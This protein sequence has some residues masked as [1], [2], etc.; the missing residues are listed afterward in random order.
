M[1]GC[2]GGGGQPQLLGATPNAGTSEFPPLETEYR[3][4]PGDELRIVVVGNDEMSVTVPVRPDGRI[5]APG[6]G[7]IEVGGRTIAIVTEELR[8]QLRRLIRYPEV[9]VM[10]VKHAEQV[11]Y[12]LGEVEAPGAKPYVPSMT[13]LHALGSAGGARRS[14]KTSSVVVLRRTGPNEMEVY[15]VDLAAALDGKPTARDFYL[16]PYDLIY[17]PRTFIA[18]LN[19]FMDQYVRQNVIPFTAYIEGWRAFH[20]KEI[21]WRAPEAQ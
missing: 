18:N 15:Q 14:G 4:Q 13:T 3:L 5:S 19:N 8:A 9:S 12:V 11:V 16:K 10:L 21:F 7:D 2:G 17:V 1:L 20:A 6:V